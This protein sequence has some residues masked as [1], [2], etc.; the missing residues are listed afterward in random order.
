M[1]KKKDT[2]EAV[3]HPGI[4]G[5]LLAAGFSRRF[6]A[7]DKLMH[8]LNTGL[9]VA[10]ASAQA[11]RQA[12]PNSVAVVREENLAL[13]GMLAALGYHVALSKHENAEMA[14]NLKLGVMAA[15]SKFPQAS[16]FVIALADMPFIQP[17][18]ITKIAD[19]LLTAA[20]VQ[21]VFNGKPGHPVG[22]SQRFT[23]ALLTIQGD[24]GARE[25]LLAHKDEILLLPCNDE[26][27]LRDID[28]MADLPGQA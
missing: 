19:Q 27:I 18:T 1:N 23:D 14:D 12:L 26:G 17:Q 15:Q 7:Q 3:A 10:G 21:P 2:T 28:T 16:G 22:F 8:T 25:I 9:T 13:Q 6:G 11:L 5:I 20:I 24:Q 4:V